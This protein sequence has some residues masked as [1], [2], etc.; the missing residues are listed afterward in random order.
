M[1]GIPFKIISETTGESHIIVTSDTGFYSTNISH[2]KHTDN[3][4]ANDKY[5][6]QDL[7]SYDDCVE[8]GIWFYGTNDKTEWAKMKVDD[9][10]GAVPYDT[11]IIEE[12]P[13]KKNEGKQ[14][15]FKTTIKVEADKD[16]KV[17]NVGVITNTDEP[18]FDTKAMDKE[19]QSHF[20][21]ADE[22]VTIQDKITY[23]RLTA[24]KTYT[25]KGI[26]MDKN[27]SDSEEGAKPLLDNNGEVI[28]AKATFTVDEKYLV[29]PN[30]KEG[31]VTVEY[32]FDGSNL[33]GESYV[34]FAY[35]FE[36]E[37]NAPLYENSGL[38]LEGAVT[39]RDGEVIRHA[40]INDENQMGTF[41]KI[42]TEARAAKTGMN[43]S[44]AEDNVEIHDKISYSGLIPNYE[45]RIEG[46]LINKATG[47]PIT[48]ADGNPVALTKHFTATGTTGEI[49]VTF[50]AIDATGMEGNATV[51]YERLYWNNTEYA[52]HT[53][54]YDTKQ[55]IYY[56]TIGTQAKDSETD[57]DRACA[58]NSVTIIDTVTYENLVPGYEYKLEGALMNKHTGKPVTTSDG[59]PVTVER[60]FTPEDF[61]GSVDVTFTLDAIDA[62]LEGEAVVCCET[63]KIKD[64]ELT[65]HKD[66]TDEGQTIYF[67]SLKTSLRDKDTG[68]Q[69]IFPDENI[70]LVDTVSYTNLVS[71]KTYRLEGTLMNK[72][73]GKAVTA[74]GK[75]V[76]ATAAFTAEKASGT[77][78]V[79]FTFDG[80]KAGLEEENELVAFEKLYYEKTEEGEK[81][82]WLIGIHEDIGDI[83]QTVSVPKIETT[84]MGKETED[85]VSNAGKKI[86]LV[87]HVAYKGLIPGKTYTMTGT[88]MTENEK[89]EPT[90][91]LA[92]GKP[93]IGQK[94]FT[95]TEASGMVDV[96]FTFDA[97]GLAGE[98]VVA[99]EDCTYKGKKVAVHMDIHDDDQTV[100]FPKIH[101]TA[102]DSETEDHISLCDEDVSII[103]T[104]TFENLPVNK[105]YMVKGVLMNKKTGKPVTDENGRQVTAEAVFNTVYPCIGTS[106]SKDENGNIIETGDSTVITEVIKNEDGKVRLVSGLVKVTFNFNAKNCNLEGVETVVFEEL[107]L[108]GEI[109]AEHKEINDGEQT[110][111]F[112]K[113]QTTAKDKAT[114]AHT[115]AGGKITIVD[116][117]VYSGL[118]P[119]KNYKLSG[120]L[121]DK[122]T[123]EPFLINGKTMR[124]E[125]SFTAKTSD[126]EE[127]LTFTFDAADLH[128]RTVVVFEVLY[129]KGKEVA[130]HT[131]IND[132]GQSV[133]FPQIKT[134]A[135]DK[136]DGDKQLAT[137]GT[138]TI[139]DTVSYTNLAE[140][141][142]YTLEGVLMDKA[143]GKPLVINGTEVTASKKFTPE[144][145]NGSVDMEFTFDVAGL[146]GR[147]LVVFEKLYLADTDIL[148]ADH[149]DINDKDQTVSITGDRHPKTGDKAPITVIFLIGVFSLVAGVGMY[150]FKRRKYREK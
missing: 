59:T 56:P 134:M 144:T 54:L 10:K 5:L 39:T 37:N 25:V 122:A 92:D 49:E 53:D 124:V 119:G 149:E 90:E 22:D 78:N 26:L 96:E 28:T 137:S 47:E 55:T 94:I 16:G 65:D 68:I 67:P 48:D 87:D 107:Y 35:L 113:L 91:L 88:L 21:A 126:C 71:G 116:T 42:E 142:A 63:L 127:E 105:I 101:T 123:G 45:Y 1:A 109:I 4:N 27:S 70:E 40:D 80:I 114:G 30:E 84:L 136:A 13:C 133:Y 143:T 57:E 135:K 44:P 66:I 117:V 51:V 104:V 69:N 29:N 72:K 85:H 147:E 139:V 20:S 12:L 23:K 102:A 125:K 121:M 86:T 7:D 17:T 3:T 62:N 64:V 118:I 150:I 77:V 6:A 140:G 82:E 32:S 33:A 115:S 98:H 131:D 58:D 146:K 103:D 73:T 81:K 83:D 89:G 100:D 112:G 95:P 24:G 50:P 106:I 148:V 108:N 19:T 36:G 34:I 120:V 79:T 74:D 128:D 31:E 75:P 130:I 110:I 61:S 60:T 8:S 11:Y 43:V 145:S 93:V 52:K 18:S 15:K 111:T 129:Y 141:E 38:N 46:I 14:I 97:S 132:K 41:P 76:T 9:T 99:F 2:Q 138:V